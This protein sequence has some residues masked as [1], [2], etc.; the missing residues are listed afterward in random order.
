MSAVWIAAILLGAGPGATVLPAA[1]AELSST[2]VQQPLV[3]LRTGVELRGAVRDALRR[4]ARVEDKQAEQAAREFLVLYKE[5]EADTK[6]AAAQREQYRGKVRGR[7]AALSTRIT[8][9]A[10]IERRLAG[11]QP[12][13]V[14]AGKGNPALGQMFGGGFG[15]PPMGGGMMGGGMPGG[16]G[17]FGNQADDAGPDLVDLIQKTIAPLTWDVNGGPGTIYYW[18]PQRALIIRQTGEVHGHV[19]D[20]INQMNAMGR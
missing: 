20:L 2:R 11:Q 5:L 10:A 9:R 3:P 7:L 18:R 14:D 8:K 4:W 12:K 13:S 17:A 15:Q 6:M 1:S 16:G 19:G